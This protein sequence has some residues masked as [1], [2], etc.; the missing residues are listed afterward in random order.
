MR[1]DVRGLLY[2]KKKKKS[3]KPKFA[4]TYCL[5]SK[6][7]SQGYK[8][9]SKEMFQGIIMNMAATSRGKMGYQ[10]NTIRG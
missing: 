1:C 8:G 10:S 7:T 5:L 6:N 3:I 9:F 4:L 2:R